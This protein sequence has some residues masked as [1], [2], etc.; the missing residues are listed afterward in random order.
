MKVSSNNL[1]EVISFG[2]RSNSVT[3]VSAGYLGDKT[4]HGM[5]WNESF[6]SSP[7][8]AYSASNWSAH[9]ATAFSPGFSRPSWNRDG[10]PAVSRCR[11]LTDGLYPDSAVPAV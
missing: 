5:K 7:G 1:D 9:L 8:S 10:A 11:Y 3:Q 2:L 4:E 6:N